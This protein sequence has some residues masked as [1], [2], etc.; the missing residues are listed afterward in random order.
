MKN[1]LTKLEWDSN[2]FSKNIAELHIMNDDDLKNPEL[3][4][5][6]YDL[7]VSKQNQDSHVEIEGLEETFRETKVVFSKHLSENICENAQEIFDTDYLPKED[8]YFFQLAYES[9]KHSRFLLDPRFGEKK[10]K[11]LYKLWVINSLNKTFAVKIFYTK[12][13]NLG[14]T[15]FVTVQQSG[16]TAKIGLIATHPLLQGKGIGRCL[17]QKAEN[18]CLENEIITMDIPTQE[19]N[20]GACNFYQKMGYA[21]KE[22]VILK[23]FWKK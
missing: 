5:N 9:G 15:G 7:I 8:E 20:V 23:H 12:D 13:E 22:R 10:F 2:F 3:N 4:N 11:E 6:Q 14:A 16:N 17:L 19:Q 18:Y 21:V 1:N